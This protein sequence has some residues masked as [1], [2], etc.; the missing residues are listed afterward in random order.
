[1]IELGSGVTLVAWARFGGVLGTGCNRWRMSCTV[2]IVVECFLLE[3]RARL[4]TAN[5]KWEITNEPECSG[6]LVF[7]L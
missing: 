2:A 6:V 1:M 3:S 5:A 4:V 7:R